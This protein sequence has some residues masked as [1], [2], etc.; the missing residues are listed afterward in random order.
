MEPVGPAYQTWRCACYQY[1]YQ[2][3]HRVI[4]NSDEASSF[5]ILY[6]VPVLQAAGMFDV[7]VPST[8]SGHGYYFWKKVNHV[9]KIQGLGIS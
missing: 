2:Y 9:L 7:R 5:D 3:R 1:L 6:P 4:L 8:S